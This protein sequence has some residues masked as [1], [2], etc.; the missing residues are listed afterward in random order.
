MSANDLLG[1]LPPK[2][3]KTLQGFVRNIF[4][5]ISSNVQGAAEIGAYSFPPLAVAKGAQGE[6]IY[7]P[8]RLQMIGQ[9]MVEGIKAIP[10][11]L[12][13]AVSDPIGTFYRKP[14]T[15]AMNLAPLVPLAGKAANLVRGA[16][17]AVARRTAPGIFRVTAGIPEMGMEIAINKPSVIKQAPVPKEVLNKVVG[18]PIINAV[19]TAKKR[20]QET[21][22]KTY[23]KYA[24][25]ENPIDEM[26]QG[27]MKRPLKT[28]DQ[29]ADDYKAAKTGEFFKKTNLGGGTEVISNKEKLA[30]LTELKRAIQQEANFNR[31]PVTLQPID[32]V[33]DA[34]LK[35]MGSEVDE[36][37]STIP[38]GKKLAKVD[39]AYKEINDIYDTVQRDLSDPG[40]AKDTM[41]RLL[42][43]D[44][45]WLTSGRMQGKVNAIRQAERISGKKI[46]E[47]ALEELTRQ[48]FNEWM[49]KGFVSHAF[50][51][52]A[53][54]TG[55]FN[56]IP[57]ALALAS[58]SPRLVRSGIKGFTKIGE[59][60]SKV[61]PKTAT[62]GAT[63][64]V[65]VASIVLQN[66]SKVLTE[67]KAKE[68]LKKA[69]GNKEEARKM[70]K[71]KGY[72]IPE[73]VETQ[74]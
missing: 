17:S 46:L 62:V 33:K 57:A 74:D 59:G 36:L 19:R 69:K 56:P 38:N 23:K 3:K 70:A 6:N 54:L 48:V 10:G 27:N 64:T 8:R 39:D 13:E 4:R 65:P 12:G 52:G 20:V 14:V 42:R 51:T 24:G 53:A 29:L 58:S 22:G 18:E 15:T 26:I 63:S 37:R 21:L 66:V 73:Y 25:V 71:R 16:T 55:F 41:M 45:T 47:P 30:A 50:K 68:F 60:I 1:V 5:D 2:N 67:E 9:G 11:E 40:K 49:G 7:N 28:F 44:N 61:S 31:A 35:K 34:A 72:E 43:G 32:T